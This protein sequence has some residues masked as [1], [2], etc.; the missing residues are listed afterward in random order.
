MTTINIPVSV[1]NLAPIR[2]G[3]TTKQAIDSM[4][5]LAQAVEKMGY[6]RYWIAEHHNSP[7]LVS[8]AT[9]ILIKHTLEHTES[10]RV[11]SG[12]V[13][14][15]NHSPLVVAEQ[16]GTMETI[17]PNRLDLGLGRAPGT[18][19]LTASALRRSKNDTVYTFPEDIKE[20]LTYFGP[21]DQQSYVRAYPGV[22][23]NIP[24]YILGSSTDSAHLAASMGLPYVFASHFAPK[25]MEAAISIYRKRFQP[26]KYLDKP[27]M[28]VC[29]NV[30]AAETDEEAALLST[31]MQQFFLNVV[32]G[33][34]IPMQPPVDN[35]D[36]LWNPM[37]R[38]MIES[39]SNMTFM[40][41]K[42]TITKQ[43]TDFQDKYNVNEIMAVSYIYDPDK[44][45][46]SYEIFKE[47]VEG[48]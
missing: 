25:Q 39:M 19:M 9:S 6:K 21:E 8:S 45:K 5:D 17:Y 13:M 10:I 23:T 42:D 37:E 20:I 4:V 36:K 27:Y 2:D 41:S 43:I 18:D 24:L 26:S 32:R 29:L 38:E 28:M 3:Q 30:I 15:P 22:D 35:M 33:T 48:R 34:K 7:T 16:F 11:G 1:L 14:L 31:S 44:Q 12:G 40:G 47:V 46:R